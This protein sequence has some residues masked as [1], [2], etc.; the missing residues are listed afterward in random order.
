MKDSGN[1]TDDF[2]NDII[3]CTNYTPTNVARLMI[4][5]AAHMAGVTTGGGHPVCTTPWVVTAELTTDRCT[6][7]SPRTVSPPPITMR[8]SRSNSLG[9]RR[10][11]G[12]KGRRHS[13]AQRGCSLVTV[14]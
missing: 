11:E 7:A 10:P 1:V 4:P 14:R 12:E 13:G 2:G 8:A 6:T 3:L 5:E 9:R